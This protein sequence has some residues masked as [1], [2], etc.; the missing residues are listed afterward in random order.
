[1]EFPE[2]LRYTKDHE[3]VEFDP[4][5][6]VAKIGITEYA[7]EKLGDVVHVELPEEESTIKASE[8][9]GSV[10]SVKAVSDIYSPV[11]GKV[12]EINT[13][14]EDSPELVNEDPY[15]EAW[16]IAVSVTDASGVDALM[17]AQ[18]YQEF[19]ESDED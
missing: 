19:I 4:K 1:M 7:Q 17:T 10:E 15:G 6:K 2:H 12:M 9:F 16:M 11:S 8:S 3:W 13:L 5:S 14:L 18:Q